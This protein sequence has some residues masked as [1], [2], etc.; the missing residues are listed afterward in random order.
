MFNRENYDISPEDSEKSAQIRRH[1]ADLAIL[2]FEAGTPFFWDNEG[3]AFK[4]M[5]SIKTGYYY[6]HNTIPMIYAAREHGYTDCRWG[7][8]LALKGAH[9]YKQDEGV[10]L[11]VW[12]NEVSVK[13]TDDNGNPVYD[14]NGHPIEEMV[15][16]SRPQIKIERLYNGSAISG[17][18]E[19]PEMPYNW[20]EKNEIKK[21]L[22]DKCKAKLVFDQT[23]NNFYV[24]DTD[25][26][27]MVPEVDWKNKDEFLVELYHCIAHSTLIDSRAGKNPFFLDLKKRCGQTNYAIEELVAEMATYR[28]RTRYGLKISDSH[29]KS[30]GEYL[31]RWADEINRNPNML[32]YTYSDSY[33][34]LNYVNDNIVQFTKEEQLALRY[35][36][37]YWKKKKN[38]KA[39]IK[40]HQERAASE[41]VAIKS[42]EVT[43]LAATKPKETTNATAKPTKPEDH[44]NITRTCLVYHPD[45]GKGVTGEYISENGKAKVFI[46]FGEGGPGTGSGLY[47]LAQLKAAHN[48]WYFGTEAVAKAEA[49][50]EA[51]KKAKAALKEKIMKRQC[52]KAKAPATQSADTP[53]KI[54]LGQVIYSNSTGKGVVTDI[55]KDEYDINRVKVKYSFMTMSYRMSELTDSEH[56][57]ITDEIK[58]ISP[59][60]PV[61]HEPA[62]S[63]QPVSEA[64]HETEIIKQTPDRQETTVHE[65]IAASQETVAEAIRE[66]RKDYHRKLNSQEAA[67]ADTVVRYVR[68]MPS[69]K[70]NEYGSSI[71]ST[72]EEFAK[73]NNIPTPPPIQTAAVK[74]RRKSRMVNLSSTAEQSNEAEL[75]RVREVKR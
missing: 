26:I 21:R 11:E 29:K 68:N 71:Q 24:K 9:L 64:K 22:L 51:Q 36:F 45:Y 25:T 42:K 46:I 49:Y 4:R 57:T 47:S 38:Q 75:A 62:A 20:M 1:T 69:E 5:V 61:V 13:K 6:Q 37:N 73:A 53:V 19:E 66:P 55:Y 48:K 32:N 56:F 23:E 15:R 65:Q 18:G 8:I 2:D 52:K 35:K 16:L 34:I 31:T 67:I 43:K 27:H 59:I 39:A 17:L 72:S 40:E 41:P 7:G 50:Y 14:K 44:G 74:A 60:K 28:F 63:S 30:H 33:A 70:Q 54:K 10:E 58:N 12:A 3:I